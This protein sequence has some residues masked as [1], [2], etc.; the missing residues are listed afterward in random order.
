[1]FGASSAEGGHDVW[2]AEREGGHDVWCAER[3]RRSRCLVHRAPKARNMVARGKGERSKPAAPG[4]I[5]KSE[6]APEGRQTRAEVFCRP[7]VPATFIFSDPGAAGSLRSPLPLATF[8]S[9]LRRLVHGTRDDY[10]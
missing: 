8:W 7:F 6:P 9:R 5:K 4:S 2:C 1:M 10:R 3:R